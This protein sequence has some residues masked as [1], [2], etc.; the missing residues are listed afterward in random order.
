MRSKSFAWA[1]SLLSL[2]GLATFTL[3]DRAPVV[4]DTGGAEMREAAV[5]FIETL[6]D[7]G[8]AA[9]LIPFEDEERFNWYYTPR[10]RRGFS[11]QNMTLEQRRAAHDL[12][13]S[14]LSRQGYLKATSIMR[15]EEIL[16]ELNDMPQLRNPEAYYFSIFGTPSADAPWG[17][18]LEGHHLSLNYSSVSDSLIAV[19]PA[20]M[21]SSPA[22][23][24]TGPYAGL[25]VLGVQEDLARELL[26]SLT[27]EQRTRAVISETAPR[28]IVTRNQRE[29]LLEQFEGLP[30]S[31]MTPAQQAILRELIHEYTHNM[32]DG[33]AQEQM[34]KIE[35]AGFD[36]LYFAW[37]GSGE[38]GQPNYHRVHGP[39]VLIEHDN[40]QSN[41][42]HIHSVWRDLTNDF[43]ED[44][45][46]L[47]YE[48][49]GQ[50]H[51]HDQ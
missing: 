38:R 25:R 18:R 9:A 16:L 1:F 12:M 46:R 6:D 33:P 41:G 8:R 42:N 30:A 26:F 50:E 39:T 44:L 31:E 40:T 47:H 27:D 23:V 15:L 19:T 5:A 20:F 14:A 17:W 28:D 13:Q 35:A 24:R 36:Q 29:A 32:K 11:I 49:A 2:A 21:G 43:G 10:D 4:Q 45:L 48:Q 3:Q 51:G 37:A 22:E 34:A 7:S